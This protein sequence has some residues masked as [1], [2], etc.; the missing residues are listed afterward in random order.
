L[1][2]A[3]MLLWNVTNSYLLLPSPITLSEGLRSRFVLHR[4]MHT[5]VKSVTSF[6]VVLVTMLHCRQDCPTIVFSFSYEVT[7][8]SIYNKIILIDYVHELLCCYRILGGVETCCFV[9]NDCLPL[10]QLFNA[11]LFWI[12]DKSK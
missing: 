6:F 5:K 4:I 12:I 2:C 7:I 10:L 9:C 1:R 11:T 3:S 8:K